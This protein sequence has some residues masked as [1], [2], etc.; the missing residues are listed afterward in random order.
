MVQKL[1]KDSC[2]W[3]VPSLFSIIRG[4]AVFKTKPDRRWNTTPVFNA[5]LM[6]GAAIYETEMLDSLVVGYLQSSFKK[7]LQGNM[8]TR[9]KYLL[10]PAYEGRLQNSRERMQELAGSSAC[11]F[12]T[13]ACEL[14]D[15]FAVHFMK[16]YDD[17]L[18][19]VMV[20]KGRDSLFYVITQFKEPVDNW[21]D[22]ERDFLS[23]LL[24]AGKGGF[25]FCFFFVS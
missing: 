11:F 20:I 16:I 23:V 18:E 2:S 21:V 1:D 6:T 14:P 10:W 24:V 5:C 25:P 8:K 15:L 7:S 4:S 22:M 13:V 17:A 9:D 12:W 19:Y 3:V